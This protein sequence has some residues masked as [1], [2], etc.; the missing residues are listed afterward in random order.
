MKRR[1]LMLVGA[2]AIGLAPL[3]TATPVLAFHH[4]GLPTACAA[5]DLASNNPT[6]KAAI[7]ENNPAQTLPL[8]P[9][10]TPSQA[11]DTPAVTNCPS[12]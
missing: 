6:A 3:G 12:A 8:P 10:G 4:V 7:Q 2:I 9:V 1:I 5:S 11:A